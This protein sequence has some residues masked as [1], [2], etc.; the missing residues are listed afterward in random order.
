MLKAGLL[1]WLRFLPL[2][3][4]AL[5]EA[6][7]VLMVAGLA[8]MFL[9]VLLHTGDQAEQLAV[10][11]VPEETTSATSSWSDPLGTMSR[12]GVP[13]FSETAELRMPFCTEAVTT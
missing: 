4:H 1:G 12:Y 3:A 6:G 13:V 9:G 2:G 8:A 10:A 7:A 11:V 5:P